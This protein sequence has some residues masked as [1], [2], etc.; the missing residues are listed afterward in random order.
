MD[1]RLVP[2]LNATA[3]A[4][5]DTL[6]E[7]LISEVAEAVINPI[8]RRKLHDCFDLAGPADWGADAADVRGEVVLNLVKKLR[9]CKAHPEDNVVSDLRGYAAVA[10]YHACAQYLRRKYPKRTALESKLR[11][12]LKNDDQ[13]AIWETAGDWLCGFA[14]W[15]RASSPHVSNRIQELIAEP[16]ELE[17]QVLRGVR[18]DLDNPI[19]ILSA[20]FRVAGGPLSTDQL[21]NVVGL[22]CGIKDHP[23]QEGGRDEDDSRASLVDRLPD[24]G[25]GLDVIAEQHRYIERL[26]MEIC[27][28]PVLQRKAL[29]LNLRDPQGRSVIELFPYL[30]VAGIRHIAEVL[31]MPGPEFAALWSDLPLEDARLAA[32]INKTRQQV[33]SLRKSARERLARRMRAF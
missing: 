26:W 2:F 22:L 10:A 28:L 33:I 25:R 23:P 4:T 31:Q 18:A 11:H 19:P 30:G 1:P 14:E 20:I 24:P 29:L 6:L 13:F 21:V 27:E 7:G 5:S 9:E 3:P 16:R 12:V 8:I 17:D 32:L 15:Q